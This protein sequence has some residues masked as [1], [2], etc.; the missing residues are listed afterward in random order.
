MKISWE[1][2]LRKSKNR[3][4]IQLSQLKITMIWKSHSFR[5]S[6]NSTHML[7]MSSKRCSIKNSQSS[8]MMK[9]TTTLRILRMHMSK[10]Y[11]NQKL[12]KFSIQ[13]Q[14]ASFG[15]SRLHYLSKT[16]QRQIHTTHSESIHSNHISISWTTKNIWTE[17]CLRKIWQTV[18]HSIEDTEQ[19][20]KCFL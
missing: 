15:T 12:S 9:N 19:S 11:H 4:I 20:I 16:K 5:N 1:K 14:I 3:K 6:N 2:N 10:I 18:F 8:R 13:F 17:D 7:L